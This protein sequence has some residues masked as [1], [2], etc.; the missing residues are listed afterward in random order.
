MKKYKNIVFQDELAAESKI[1]NIANKIIC[2]ETLQTLKLLPD[3]SV[4]LIVTSPSYFL[5]K[6]YEENQTFEEYLSDHK[7]IIK[8]CKRVLKDDGS[9]YWNVAQSIID[10]ET[11]HLSSHF[12]SIFKELDFFMK[13]NIIWKFEGGETPRSRL[14]GRYENI[15]W[16]VNDKKN[17]VFNVDDVRVPTKWLKDKRVRKDGKNPEDFW[18]FDM[19]SNKEKL[20]SFKSKLSKYKNL[21][22]Q[23]SEDYVNQI[24]MDEIFRDLEKEVDSVLST[25]DKIISKNI[26]DNIWHINRVVNVS[27]TQ[28]IKHPET[29]LAHPCPFPE[30][31]INRIIKMGSNENDLVLDIFSG[32]GTVFKVADSLNRRWLGIDKELEYC[33]IASFRFE[34]YIKSKQS[35]QLKLF[36]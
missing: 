29:G 30:E 23:N 26:L 21:L 12:Y 14:F 1:E 33:E 24:H 16:F 8:E 28:K 11:I 27:K 17:Y 10:N 19:R 15:M 20:L 3:N 13:N 5:G 18:E 34:E 32:S 9:I 2:G 35:P 4:N 22:S 36:K 6:K 7:K 25:S 31:L